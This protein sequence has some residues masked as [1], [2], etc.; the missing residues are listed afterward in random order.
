MGK[1]NNN[2]IKLKKGINPRF[3]K[4]L[5]VFLIVVAVVVIGLFAAQEIGNVTINSM[6]DSVKAV[7]GNMGSGE[8]FP[9]ELG[10]DSIVDVSLN[11][12]NLFILCG[13][14]TTVLNST[15]KEIN[16]EKLNFSNP[17]MKTKDAFAIV[18]DLDSDKFRIQNGAEII[19]EGKAEGKIMSAAVGRRGNYA[20]GTY[21]SN[22]QSTLSVYNKK[23]EA[24][25]IWDFKSE[26][27]SDISLSDSG[28]NA[29]VT[30]VYSSEGKISSRVYVFDFSS[31]KPVAKL[32]YDSSVLI[33][34]DYIRN[35]DIVVLGDNIRSYIKDGK[36]RKDDQQFKTDKLNSYCV[37]NQGRS[38]LVR[39]KYGS[40]SLCTL[41]VYSS[42]NKLQFTTDFDKEVKGVDCGE[43]YT[44]VLFDNEIKTFDKKGRE[45]GTIKFSGEPSRV[46]VSGTDVYVFTSVSIQCY[47]VKGNEK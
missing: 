46:I 26:R 31:E 47:N 36:I 12:S 32:D 44:A 24:L 41:E 39:S 10:A 20:L 19:R 1:E 2:I 25:F 7:V 28:K 33:H 23:G 6:T 35:N 43:R 3:K 27:I 5:I 30:T 45:K 13:D 37:N 15:A 11:N 9:Y 40:S 18:Y 21:G 42:K 29:A 34:V 17:V 14:E 8:G 4:A 16:P 38:A 22:V